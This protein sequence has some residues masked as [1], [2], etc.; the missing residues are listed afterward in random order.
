M[1]YHPDNHQD[2]TAMALA[3]L[4]VCIVQTLDESNSAFRQ[5]VV[6]V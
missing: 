1:S 4:T 6:V 5:P 2:Q 3:A